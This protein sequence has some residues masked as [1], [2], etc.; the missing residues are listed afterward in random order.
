MSDPWFFEDV[1]FNQGHAEEAVSQLRLLRSMVEALIEVRG[2]AA[3]EPLVDWA[4]RFR[5]DFD[6]ELATT[7]NGLGDVCDRIDTM[8][9]SINDGTDTAA[10]A[11]ASRE[12]LRREHEEGDG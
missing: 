12:R 2:N 8:I 4:G 9:A 7:Q 3:D 5:D 10:T 1:A 11:Q 6:R